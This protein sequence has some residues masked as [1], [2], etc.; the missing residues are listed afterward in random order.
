MVYR[1]IEVLEDKPRHGSRAKKRPRKAQTS[2]WSTTEVQEIATSNPSDEDTDELSSHD[3]DNDWQNEVE[4]ED[5]LTG[6]KRVRIF[7]QTT[8]W[9]PNDHSPYLF[10]S[11]D[12][13]EV[14]YDGPIRRR[15][16]Y[17]GSI[18]RATSA[19]TLPTS[20][21]SPIGS[22]MD[23]NDITTA[24][25]IARFDY[26]EMQIIEAGFLGYDGTNAPFR[27]DSGHVH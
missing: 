26:F 9:D 18:A 10:I 6:Y 25:E 2:S 23:I 21:P 22:H 7:A 15:G 19:F 12:G 24:P 14:W 20:T 27:T 17:Q 3:D 13:L 8:K 4:S 1:R 16:D 11:E 5:D